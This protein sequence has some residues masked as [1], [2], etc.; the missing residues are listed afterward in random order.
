[1]K[2]N[3]LS[4][5]LHAEISVRVVPKKDRGGIK[6]NGRQKK[7]NYHMNQIVVTPNEIVGLYHRD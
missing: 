3:N 7:C 4:L 5:G 1:M 6:N 2:A